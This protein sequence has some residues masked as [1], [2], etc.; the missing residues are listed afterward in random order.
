MW[1]C[2]SNPCRQITDA[3]LKDLEPL[4]P[5]CA[6]EAAHSLED[7]DRV[8]GRYQVVN[9]KL[10]KTGGLT[11]AL[12]LCRAARARGLGIMAGGMVGTSLGIAP[13]LHIARMADFVDLDGPWWLARDRKPA[14][15]FDAGRLVSPSAGWG[16]PA[17]AS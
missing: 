9:V 4:V 1:T 12:E 3:G 14:I 8:A 13:A 11:A 10:D 6:D 15:R 17:S 5:F 16:L 7:L 2:W